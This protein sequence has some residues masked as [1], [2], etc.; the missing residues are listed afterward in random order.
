MSA[1][2]KRPATNRVVVTNVSW[3]TYESLL[4]DLENQSSPRLAYDQGVLEIMSPHFEHDR[5][6]HILAAIAVIALEEM[7]VDFEGAGS[8]TFKREVLKRGFEPDSSFFIRNAERVRGKKRLDMEIDPPPDLLIEIDVTSDS[9]NKF[10][11]YAALGVPEVWRYE[12]TVEIW[13]LDRG[14]YVRRHISAAIPILTEKVISEFMNSSLTM[15]RPAWSRQVRKR[16]R[17]LIG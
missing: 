14:T 17:E 16:I 4:K 15:K 6:N 8:T 10:P 5:S 7:D 2:T 11:L 13:V 1:V 9:M 12:D 3:E